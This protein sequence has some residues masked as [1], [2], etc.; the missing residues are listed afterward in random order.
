MSHTE[1]PAIAEHPSPW[2]FPDTLER[3]TRAITAAG[4]TILATI[5]HAA[6]ARSVGLTMP[7]TTVLIYGS[8]K[9]G[10]PVMVA[11]P[12]AALD[13][14][15]RVLV[16]ECPHGITGIAFHPVG[17]MLVQAGSSEEAAAKLEPAQRVLLAA[18]AP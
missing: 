17:A 9:G 15:L 4:M 7:P 12:L 2:P 3:L 5:D 11:A 13:L 1:M 18:L 14:P 10:T 8:P 6:N 16:R